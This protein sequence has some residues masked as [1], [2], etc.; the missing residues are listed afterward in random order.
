M[1]LGVYCFENRGG[2]VFG[3]YWCCLCW[4]GNVIMSVSSL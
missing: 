2:G 1:K 3:V 4:V